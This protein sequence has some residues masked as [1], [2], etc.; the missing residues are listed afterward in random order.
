MDRPPARACVCV[1][2]QGGRRRAN[3]TAE[4]SPF[5]RAPI[6]DRPATLTTAAPLSGRAHRITNVRRRA[7]MMSR[8]VTKVGGGGVVLH[9]IRK[10]RIGSVL[11]IQ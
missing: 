9:Q 7:A 10:G 1:R 5:N 3:P 8:A 6:V 4:S 11:Y 2:L